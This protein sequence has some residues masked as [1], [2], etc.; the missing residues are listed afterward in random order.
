M[1]FELSALARDSAVVLMV[2]FKS[3]SVQWLALPLPVCLAL[4]N[5]SRLLVLHS[6]LTTVED[7][8]VISLVTS[9]PPFKPILDHS[10]VSVCSPSYTYLPAVF[11]PTQFHKGA[12]LKME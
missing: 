12:I 5:F 8:I 6:E 2:V 11:P 10:F 3:L 4:W 9:L 7:L 1:G